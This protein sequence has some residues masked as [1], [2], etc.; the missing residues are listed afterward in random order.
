MQFFLSFLPAFRRLCLCEGP[1]ELRS[2]FVLFSFWSTINLTCCQTYWRCLG[3]CLCCRWTCSSSC[4]PS[5]CHRWGP[6]GRSSRGG[7]GTYG[8]P[9]CTPS[10]A[11]RRTALRSP[12]CKIRDKSERFL[13][14]LI[15]SELDH[16]GGRRENS[17]GGN[18]RKLFC[19]LMKTKEG[20]LEDKEANLI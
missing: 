5:T 14:I 12:M 6:P 19:Y 17:Q 11:I 3:R 15:D 1:S 4:L 8:G 9:C 7:G 16:Q 18:K 10:A 2:C 13:H 20:E